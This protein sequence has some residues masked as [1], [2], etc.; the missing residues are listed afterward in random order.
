MERTE[1]E[2]LAGLAE[3]IADEMGCPAEAVRADST[4]VDD[5]EIDWF[6]RLAII[7]AAE[8]VFGSR[9]PLADAPTFA[10]VGDLAARFAQE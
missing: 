7:T 9:V 5:L 6:S 10:T 1:D 4:L 8:D 2:V 3:I